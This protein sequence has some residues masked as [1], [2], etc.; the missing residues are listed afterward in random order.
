[1]NCAFQWLNRRGG[2][3]RSFNWET[4]TQILERMKVVCPRI[5]EA[6]CRRVFA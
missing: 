6:K 5:T 2:K 3:R 1:M 4:F